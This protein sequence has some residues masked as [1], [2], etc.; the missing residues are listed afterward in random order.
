MKDKRNT[1]TWHNKVGQ[2]EGDTLGR[3]HTKKLAHQKADTPRNWHTEK[4]AHREADTPRRWHTKKLA[5]QES[6]HYLRATFHTEM[7]KQIVKE[8]IFEI[9]VT[10][11]TFQAP[12]RPLIPK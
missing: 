6:L 7:T 2:Y 12:E 11:K 4:L 1:V 9:T 8:A 5:K 10:D 3:W